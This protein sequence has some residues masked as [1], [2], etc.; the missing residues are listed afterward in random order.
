VLF[1]DPLLPE[2][3][4]ELMVCRPGGVSERPFAKDELDSDAAIAP[5]IGLGDV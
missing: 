5:R 2:E 3:D 4:E 1:V